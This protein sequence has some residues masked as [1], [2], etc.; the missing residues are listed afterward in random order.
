MLDTQNRGSEPKTALT[1]EIAGR[2]TPRKVKTS[3]GALTRYQCFS[4]L[5][6]Q[7]VEHALRDRMVAGSIPT[8]G[9]CRIKQMHRRRHSHTRRPMMWLRAALSELRI[10]CG[11]C[12]EA[13]HLWS[14]GYD[15]SST[16]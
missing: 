13:W 4:C 7:R 10:C 8:G 9:F 14:S 16:R 11:V 1:H 6:S 15:V 3:A 2:S 5:L 12:R